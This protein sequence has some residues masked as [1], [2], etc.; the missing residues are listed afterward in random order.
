MQCRCLLDSPFFP[1]G[2]SALP[3]GFSRFP[4]CEQNQKLI[5]FLVLFA[6]SPVA[7]FAVLHTPCPYPLPENICLTNQSALGNPI[8]LRH[9]NQSLLGAKNQ[10]YG[11]VI[12]TLPEIASKFL[13]TKFALQ[14][15]YILLFLIALRN[16]VKK[17]NRKLIFPH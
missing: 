14:T 15:F 2:C 7:A 4:R 10:F 5:K 12:K 9:L 13:F 3:L 11:S 6:L 17:S 8:F 16:S 1:P